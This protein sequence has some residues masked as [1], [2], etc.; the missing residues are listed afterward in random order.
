MPQ[1]MQPLQIVK[2]A[3]L[4]LLGFALLLPGFLGSLMVLTVDL[5]GVAMENGVPMASPLGEAIQNPAHLWIAFAVGTLMVVMGAILIGS[6]PFCLPAAIVYFMCPIVC[7]VHLLGALLRGD[8]PW[9]RIA[10]QAYLVIGAVAAFVGATVLKQGPAEP[11]QMFQ[12]VSSG[13]LFQFGLAAAL[14]G[15]IRLRQNPNLAD[16]LA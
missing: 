10:A 2:S 3:A 16:N 6:Q 12:F 8:K 11:E 4:L 1:Q 5:S 15:V 7:L 9:N 14:G 13:F